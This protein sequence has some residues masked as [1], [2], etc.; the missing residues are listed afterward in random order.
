MGELAF[1]H[2]FDPV[3]GGVPVPDF[4]SRENFSGKSLVKF[5]GEIFYFEKKLF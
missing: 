5:S 2:F 3:A 4:S 1:S